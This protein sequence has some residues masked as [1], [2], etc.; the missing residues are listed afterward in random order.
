MPATAFTPPVAPNTSSD[1]GI[2]FRTLEVDF[3]DGYSQRSGDGLNATKRT[4]SFS[5]EGLTSSQATEIENFIL[6][7][8]GYRAFTYTLPD[9]STSRVWRPMPKSFKRTYGN[10]GLYNLSFQAE[11][12]FDIDV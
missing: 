12:V 3:G 10:G 4:F 8:A 5:W 9:E 7:Q 1:K 6:T 11:E 2:E